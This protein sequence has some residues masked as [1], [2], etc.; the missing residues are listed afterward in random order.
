M[1]AFTA[2]KPPSR[3]ARHSYPTLPTVP[4]AP[5]VASPTPSR[6]TG[7]PNISGPTGNSAA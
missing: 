6:T 1:P 4:N 5:L 2:A 7:A 3:T